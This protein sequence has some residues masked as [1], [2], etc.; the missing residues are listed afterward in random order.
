MHN[1]EWIRIDSNLVHRTAIVYPNVTLGVNNIIGAYCVI[2]SNGEIRNKKFSEFSG[3]VSIGDNN[4][5][6]EHV[7][8]QRPFEEDEL[9]II[10]NEC[11]IM[12]HSHIGH[13]A[14][15]GNNVEICTSSVIGGYATIQDNVKIKLNST[16]RN[17]ITINEGAL[18]GMGSV[19]VK[20]VPEGETVKGN[21]AKT[22]KQ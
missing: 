18:V 7:T 11:L 16:I 21:P 17:R 15:I 13:D 6:S 19:V 9:T 3:S 14:W 12:A 10:G 20:D 1:S 2:G 8:I 4:R 22:N 5:I